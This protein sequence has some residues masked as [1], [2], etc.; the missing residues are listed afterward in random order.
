MDLCNLWS[1]KGRYVIAGRLIIGD[2]NS[3]MCSGLCWRH[4]LL[5]SNVGPYPIGHSTGQKQKAFSEIW[6]VKRLWRRI[7]VLVL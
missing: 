1:V 4:R 3:A 5:Y 7:N 2:C 6:N